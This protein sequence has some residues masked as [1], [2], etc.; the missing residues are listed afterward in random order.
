MP[1]DAENLLRPG[2]NSWSTPEKTLQSPR[3][4]SGK[5][6]PC[7]FQSGFFFLSVGW[8]QS[9]VFCHLTRHDVPRGTVFK[10]PPLGQ[11]EK[12]KVP[13]KRT[14]HLPRALRGICFRSGSSG[15]WVLRPPNSFFPEAPH[16][17]L[18]IK[19]VPIFTL[20]PH[21]NLH[22]THFYPVLVCHSTKSR[23]TGPDYL[24]PPVYMR[25]PAG[26]IHASCPQPIR[27]S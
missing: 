10:P 21:Y 12:S 22:S 18:F 16:H 27:H 5:P 24:S 9:R 23:N 2:K 1:L 11:R 14:R 19:T 13:A 20:T 4:L 17:P 3:H 26:L 15:K 6:C 25:P 8:S 7:P